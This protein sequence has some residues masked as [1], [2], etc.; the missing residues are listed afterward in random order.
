MSVALDNEDS[1]RT[2][3]CAKEKGAYYT[4][5]QVVR[6]LLSWAVRSD[7][8]RLLDPSCGD[9]RF[10]AGHLKSVGIERDSNASASAMRRA[11]SAL[12]HKCDFFDWAG[13]HRRALRMRRLATR[14]LSAINASR[15]PCAS[16]RSTCVRCWVSVFQLCRRLG[17][18]SLSQ[19]PIFCV[20]VA[21]WL[22]WSQPKLAMPR[23]APP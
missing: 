16:G 5:D 15:A 10:L 1:R 23:T 9:G 6:S 4:P 2:V 21:A 22:S 18:C 19:P 13:Q 8:D 17:R 14:R 3:E 20:E 12:V 11:P 7:E